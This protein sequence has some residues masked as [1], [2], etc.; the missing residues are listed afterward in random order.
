M[1][2]WRASASCFFLS[3]SEVALSDLA[4]ACS[5]ARFSR[6]MT[7][8]IFWKILKVGSGSAAA[9]GCAS[10]AS[11]PS[12]S[13]PTRCNVAFMGSSAHDELVVAGVGRRRKHFLPPSFADGVPADLNH[14]LVERVM[15][16]LGVGRPIENDREP[17]DRARG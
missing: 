3:S 9:G 14:I 8:S 15:V 11:M 1:V 12:Q 7:S 2:A 16:A 10:A 5:A 13:H 17:D 4:R 6:F